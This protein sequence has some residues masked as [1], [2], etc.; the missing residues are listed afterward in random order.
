VSA[1]VPVRPARKPHATQAPPQDRLRACV[2]WLDSSR[3]GEHIE[4]IANTPAKLLAVWGACALGEWDVY[5]DQLSKRQIRE[6]I[7]GIPPQFNDGPNG[8]EPF[9][10]KRGHP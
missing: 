4:R 3:M 1:G 5:A 7:R 6:A 10:T 2:R 8:L 9:Y